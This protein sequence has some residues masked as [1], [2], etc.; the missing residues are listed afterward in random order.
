MA[1]RVHAKGPHLIFTSRSFQDKVRTFCMNPYGH[2]SPE[3]NG[4]VIL[5][6]GHSYSE[7][8]T[9]NTNFAL[10]V[11]TMFTEPFKEPTAYGKYI[12]RLANLIGGG[13]IIQRLGDL[14]LGRRSP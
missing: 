1:V 7:E 5:V 2:V 4:D 12:A 11:S 6:N 8:K 10:L 13:I 3:L 9:D 14:M